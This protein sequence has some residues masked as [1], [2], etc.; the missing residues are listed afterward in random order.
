MLNETE[1]AILVK[2]YFYSTF[3]IQHLIF[4]DLGWFDLSAQ[5]P[6]EAWTSTF[7]N[8][9]LAGT[10]KAPDT[11]NLSTADSFLSPLQVRGNTGH[12]CCRPI[13]ISRLVW[14][15]LMITFLNLNSMTW[16]YEV[17]SSYNNHVRLIKLSC[18]WPW[19]S[20]FFV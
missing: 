1:Y 7:L 17:T 11:N 20:W 8:N 12:D 16:H 14:F 3:S 2:I 18:P 9:V 4:Y 5:Y 13:M 19:T 15:S 10:I 6:T